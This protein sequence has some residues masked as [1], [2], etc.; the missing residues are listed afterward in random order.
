LERYN[1]KEKFIEEAKSLS[2]VWKELFV[3]ALSVAIGIIAYRFNNIL[4]DTVG[5]FGR[6][7]SII[8]LLAV[9]NEYRLRTL[10]DRQLDYFESR[11]VRKS[12]DEIRK[13]LKPQVFL[14]QQ[15]VTVLTHLQVIAG[16]VIWGFG[17]L[18]A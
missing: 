13:I 1:N 10:R 14:G 2:W 5:L 12:P 11:N 17:D 9:V 15:I 7:G 3:L 8:V 18:V 6:S 16:T 4:G